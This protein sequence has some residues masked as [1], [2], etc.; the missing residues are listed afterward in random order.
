MPEAA[1]HPQEE[2]PCDWWA[3]WSVSLSF[4]DVALELTSFDCETLPFEPGLST[5]TWVFAFFAPYWLAAESDPASWALPADWPAAWIPAEPPWCWLESWSVSLSFVAFASDDAELV[6]ETD[7]S[8]PGL[9]TRTETFVLLGWIC[10]APDAAPAACSFVADCP[11]TCTPSAAVAVSAPTERSRRA[12][13]TTDARN[14]L[15][16]LVLLPSFERSSAPARRPARGWVEGRPSR[17]ARGAR[18]ARRA[19]AARSSP[20][21]SGR[22]RARGSRAR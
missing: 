6:C 2:P 18:G 9:S 22:S 12:A 7:P 20:R 13:P 3:S 19:G 11:A 1:S 5:R 4:L 21:A 10:V 15:V 8:S 17:D 14:R 16:N